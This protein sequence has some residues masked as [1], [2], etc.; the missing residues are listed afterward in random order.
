MEVHRVQR[1][2]LGLSQG[3]YII[4][5]RVA[6]HIDEMPLSIQLSNKHELW[7]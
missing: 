4:L 7:G 5:Y 6:H 1:D 3:H 2:Y